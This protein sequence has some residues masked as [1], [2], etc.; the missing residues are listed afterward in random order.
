VIRESS[1]ERISFER[2]MPADTGGNPRSSHRHTTTRESFELLDGD[3]TATIDGRDHRLVR[4]E[5]LDI[6]MGSA[7]TNPRTNDD[8]T[9]TIVHSVSPCPRA[10]E[11][12]FVSWFRW[13]QEG[14]ADG[15][16]EPTTLQLAAI[17]R[18]GGFGGTWI[19]GVPIFLQR[20][21]LPLLGFVAHV[22]GTR[23]VR[24]PTP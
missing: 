13:H 8:T 18:E 5:V 10:V 7:H 19:A 22:L 17:T 1:P 15:H 6:P 12:Y 20:L 11:V 23:A 16:D 4:G 14:K 3:A 24:V 2:T 9:A 21:G